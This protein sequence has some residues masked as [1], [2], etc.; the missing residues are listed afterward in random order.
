M[1]SK[2][3]VVRVRDPS[4]IFRV[5]RLLKIGDLSCSLQEVDPAMP[6]ERQANALEQADRFW[7]NWRERVDG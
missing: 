4:L 2:N 1:V 7:A 5:E 6:E 3:A